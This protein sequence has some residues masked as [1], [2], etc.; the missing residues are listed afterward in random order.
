MQRSAVCGG[1]V[2]PQRFAGTC[3]CSVDWTPLGVTTRRGKDAP[4]LQLNRLIRQQ[5]TRDAQQAQLIPLTGAAP[6]L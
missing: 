5:R 6:P 1:L 3:Y 2:D 4:T